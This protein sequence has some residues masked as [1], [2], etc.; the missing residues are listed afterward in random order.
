MGRELPSV[1]TDLLDAFSRRRSRVLLLRGLG[2]AALVLVAAVAV[3]ACVDGLAR[4]GHGVRVLLTLATYASVAAVLSVRAVLP[5]VRRRRPA[6]VAMDLE[7]AAGGELE[8]RLS[9]AVELAELPPPGVSAWMIERTVALASQN[10]SALS[11]GTLVDVEPARRS[12]ARGGVAL[13]VALAACAV[14]PARTLA[15]RALGANLGRPA[16]TKLVVAPGDHRLAMGGGITISAEATPPADAPAPEAAV[17]SI[18][19]DDGLSEEI[20]M[21]RS[22]SAGS[23]LSEIE[24]LT[25]GFTYTVSSADAESPRFTVTVDTPPK[26]KALALRVVPPE[27]SGMPELTVPGGDAEVLL[28][29]AVSVTAELEGSEAASATLAFE[30][31]ATSAMELTGQTATYSWKP[32][33]TARFGLRLVGRDGLVAELAQRWLLKVVPDVK[34]TCT[35]AGAGLDAGLVGSEELLLLEAK[36]NDDIG[37]QKLELVVSVGGASVAKAQDGETRRPIALPEGRCLRVVSPVA[38][39]LEDFSLSVGDSV[40]LCLEATDVGGQVARGSEI[41]LIAAAGDQ[42]KLAATAARL[43]RELRRLGAQAEHLRQEEHA[44]KELSRAFRPED[45]GAQRGSILVAKERVEA[46]TFAIGKVAAAVRAEAMGVTTKLASRALWVADEIAEW[47]E[48]QGAILGRGAERVVKSAKDERLDALV[49]EG[50]LA[51]AA[52]E[53]LGHLRHE[54]G[55]LVARIEAEALVG[56]AEAADARLGR[57]VPVVRGHRGWGSA[58]VRPGL[59]GRF[60]ASRDL[61][62]PPVHRRSGVVDIQNLSVPGIGRDNWSVRFAGDVHVLEDG[63]YRFVTIVDDGVRLRVA[64]REIIGA[65]A[66]HEQGATPYEGRIALKAGWHPLE[67]QMYQGGGESKLWLG[68]AKGAE[69]P[70]LIPKERLRHVGDRGSSPAALLSEMARLPKEVLGQADVRLAKDFGTLSRVPPTIA[71]MAEDA[72]NRA[73]SDLARRHNKAGVRL[74][75]TSESAEKTGCST[76]ELEGAEGDVRP[77]VAAARQARAI[78]MGQLDKLARER[79]FGHG[80]VGALRRAAARIERQTRDIPKAARDGAPAERDSLLRKA[81]TV[82]EAELEELERAT[83]RERGGFSRAAR[84]PDAGLAERLSAMRAAHELATEGSKAL[85]KT[86][87]GF[88]KLDRRNPDRFRDGNITRGLSEFERSLREAQRAEEDV[89]TGRRAE[90]AARALEESERIDAARERGSL[91]GEKRAY[92][93]LAERTAEL[94]AEARRQGQFDAADDLETHL[95]EDA[96][97]LHHEELKGRLAHAVREGRSI[98]ARTPLKFADRMKEQV[99]RL[100]TRKPEETAKAGAELE[101]MPFEMTLASEQLRHKKD[102]ERALAWEQLG[103][104]LDE[105]LGEPGEVT[106]EELKPLAER[107]ARIEG[108]RG[109]QRSKEEMAKAEERAKE[110]AE[111]DPALAEAR[112]LGGLARKPERAARARPPR[113]RPARR[114]RTRASLRA[115]RPR[116]GRRPRNSSAC[117]RRWQGRAPRSPKRVAASPRP[118]RGS[119]A[120]SRNSRKTR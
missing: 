69:G 23:F 78:L 113:T 103:R 116:Q 3:T 20:A 11:P 102:P 88:K 74:G 87:D 28:G 25:R 94:A 21:E 83:E 27:Y 66:W 90:L 41:E 59:L 30:P 2:E 107:A 50:D 111:R 53:E 26:L 12:L 98:E 56:G 62:G 114:P 9:S 91:L 112:R 81:R 118:R 31:G 67:L 72:E 8:E 86:V 82:M 37:I 33:E 40:R 57:T 65:N 10:A 36:A 45:P 49:D 39:N 18:E 29:S 19:W 95:G 51:A 70:K 4:P 6:E 89:G 22:D 55:V 17:I 44:W 97:S 47:S 16:R 76:T 42:A 84:R 13:V 14:P 58:T 35:L 7:R 93:D 46:V 52:G 101:D 43:R 61:S 104:D 96:A 110:E 68:L 117:A 24:V 34:P 119:R 38:L 106:A 79:D 77:L 115:S 32:E 75:A 108:K 71:Q 1:I 63:E 73:L 92:D 48:T 109:S 54:F 15:L 100:G 85:A 60:H 5:A 99:K 64:G 105:V 80:R 120:R